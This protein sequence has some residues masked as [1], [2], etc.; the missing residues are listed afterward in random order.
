MQSYACEKTGNIILSFSIHCKSSPI[1]NK[2]QSSSLC[3]L[4]WNSSLQAGVY[5]VITSLILPQNDFA[6]PNILASLWN[7]LHDFQKNFSRGKRRNTQAFKISFVSGN[8]IITMY[9]F[10]ASSNKTIFKIL[11]FFLKCNK[12]IIVCNTAYFCNF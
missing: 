1:I 11:C 4:A 5:P 2:V 9:G 12:N 10:S 8:N 3:S 7:I 6:K